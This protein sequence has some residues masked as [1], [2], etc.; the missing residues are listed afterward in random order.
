MNFS[1]MMSGF[2]QAASVASAASNAIQGVTPP[3]AAPANAVSSGGGG[4]IPTG[5]KAGIGL[6]GLVGG[7]LILRYFRLIPKII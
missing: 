1:D 2:S 4:E 7:Y 5:G 3:P 6:A